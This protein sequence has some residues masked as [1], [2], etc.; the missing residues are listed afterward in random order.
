MNTRRMRIIL[1]CCVLLLNVCYMKSI[2]IKEGSKGD[3]SEANPFGTLDEAKDAIE[4]DVNNTINHVLLFPGTYIAQTGEFDLR[5]AT[6]NI[7]ITNVPGHAR[8]TLQATLRAGDVNDIHVFTL[9]V[10]EVNF[11]SQKLVNLYGKLQSVIFENCDFDQTKDSSSDC[12]KIKDV[13][14]YS[15]GVVFRDCFFR[16]NAFIISG[17]A[18]WFS[19]DGKTEGGKLIF[20]N[21]TAQGN[22]RFPTPVLEV[23]A[24]RG[25]S[26]GGIIVKN[27]K[28][29]NGGALR[30]DYF[31]D[32]EFINNE[33]EQS[34]MYLQGDV[35]NIKVM[36][37]TFTNFGS[38]NFVGVQQPASIFFSPTSAIDPV[39][40]LANITITHN[41][42]SKYTNTAE[43]TYAMIMFSRPGNGKYTCDNINIHMNAFM[44]ADQ[45]SVGKLEDSCIGI[46]AAE[47][48][49][50][51]DGGPNHCCNPGGKGTYIAEPIEDYRSWCEDPDCLTFKYKK[52]NCLF[53]TD[54]IKWVLYIGLPLTATLILSILFIGIFIFYR[55]RSRKRFAQR[56]ADQQKKLAGE[57]GSE[58]WM[59]DREM[60]WDE[61][62][63]YKMIA[64]KPK[65]KT[66]KEYERCKNIVNHMKPDGMYI[67]RAY[68]IHNKSL[69]LQFGSA[70]QTILNKW[71]SSSSIFNT[72]EWQR[73]DEDRKAR[74]FVYE[75]YQKYTNEFVWNE[76]RKEPKS[77]P[78]MPVLH[79]TDENT[80]WKICG[81][82]FGTVAQVDDGFYGQGMYFTSDMKYATKYARR[83]N[84]GEVPIIIAFAAPGN[85]YPTIEHPHSSENSLKGQPGKP[86][87]QSHFVLVDK[88]GLPYKEPKRK[89][90][91]SRPAYFTTEFVIFQEAQ[92]L[93]TYVV[94]M[95]Y[96]KDNGVKLDD[97]EK[98]ELKDEVPA[99]RAL[100]KNTSNG[101]G[102]ALINT[103]SMSLKDI[104]EPSLKQPLLDKPKSPPQSNGG[105]VAVKPDYD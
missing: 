46:N 83:N 64:L 39:S 101:N 31:S 14:I 73:D 16:S 9:L 24:E 60:D 102:A 58:P 51:S 96:D 18:M 82:G 74:D 85:V 99:E 59:P 15:P 57:Y 35:K 27:S 13:T 72:K 70:I 29:L 98:D 69:S 19:L 88:K 77:M 3:G 78:V 7:S 50:G 71:Q 45:W 89:R 44:D 61:R 33:F 66:G 37:N 81:S 100:W 10:S 91:K 67:S 68:Q 56:I 1:V 36:N 4:A 104:N 23:H 84:D 95:K 38:L 6:N 105:W 47:N 90:R 8:P 2:Y 48:W 80:C 12:I 65:S 17:G 97:E 103:N 34:G 20:D 28:F 54:W 42:F 94:F 53:C 55:I 76:E 26:F 30:L 25:T 21:I 43:D 11:K 86:G 22:A 62:P 5:G 52:P 75:Q 87:Y 93:P 49:F 40:I 79:G 92:V 41:T 63:D 32:S